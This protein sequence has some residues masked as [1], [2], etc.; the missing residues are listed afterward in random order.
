MSTD[1]TRKAVGVQWP[2]V[3]VWADQIRQ[4]FGFWTDIR[5]GPP[6]PSAPKRGKWG[7]ISVTLAKYQEG[8]SSRSIHRWAYLCDPM[9]CRAEDQALQLLVAMHQQLDT[10]AWEAERATRPPAGM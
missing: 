9:R 10:E 1:W 4:E 2:D 6:L 8:G 3:W 7:T 5:I